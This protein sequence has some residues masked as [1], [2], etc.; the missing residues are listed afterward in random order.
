MFP[1]YG[2]ALPEAVEVTVL[3]TV[4]VAPPPT[5]EVTVLVAGVLEDEP[6][7]KYPAAAPTTRPATAPPTTAPVPTALRR[8]TFVSKILLLMFS[9][10]FL[11][12]TEFALFRLVSAKSTYDTTYVI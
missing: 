8:E 7:A 5:V 9:T 4:C 12:F 10:D 3:V 1:V 11:G 2:P 6:W